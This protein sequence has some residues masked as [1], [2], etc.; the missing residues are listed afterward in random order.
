MMLQCQRYWLMPDIFDE[1]TPVVS[2][3]VLF[4][5]ALN[6]RLFMAIFPSSGVHLILIRWTYIVAAK[7]PLK[8]LPK[9]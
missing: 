5:E 2:L 3:R 8:S 4:T 7:T 6:L 1:C 9:S